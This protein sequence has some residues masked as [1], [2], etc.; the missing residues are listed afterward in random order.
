MRDK[1]TFHASFTRMLQN[2][3]RSEHQKIIDVRRDRSLRHAS[4]RINHAMSTA[5]AFLI[6][7]VGVTEC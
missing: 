1:V 2:R 7:H 5:A 4:Y 3:K 6:Q